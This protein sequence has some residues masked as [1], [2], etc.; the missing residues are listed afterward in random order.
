MLAACPHLE[1]LCLG[2]TGVDIPSVLPL[3]EANTRG[4]L[5]AMNMRHNGLHDPA[6]LLWFGSEASRAI[7]TLDLGG[8]P[9]TG[10]ALM[11]ARRLGWTRAMTWLGIQ[12]LGLSATGVLPLLRGQAWPRL[13]TLE[14]GGNQVARSLSVLATQGA[15]GG[16]PALRAL[17]LCDT[18]ASIREVIALVEGLGT[19]RELAVDAS[20]CT[21]EAI[22]FAQEHGVALVA[23]LPTPWL[24]P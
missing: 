4:K 16:F 5:H 1:Q 20:L 23:N 2:H 18:G 8:N 3:L 12:H 22:D 10:H 7:H 14:L 24:V 21:P 6:M 19:L 15:Q 11:A 9:I 13:R 17:G